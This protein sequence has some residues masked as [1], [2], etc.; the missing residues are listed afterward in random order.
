MSPSPTAPTGPRPVIPPGSSTMSSASSAVLPSSR[1]HRGSASPRPP[2]HN[3]DEPTSDDYKD[4]YN[5][6]RTK[7]LDLQIE[8]N[9]RNEGERKKQAQV[10]I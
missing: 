6:V 4:K 7:F 9:K 5:E 10:R 8:L 1:S 2:V 3:P